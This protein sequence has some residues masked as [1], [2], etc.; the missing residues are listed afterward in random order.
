[1]TNSLAVVLPARI[2]LF[3]EPKALWY[4]NRASGLV[5]LVL[6]TIVL[7]FG[8]MA[9]RK[10][11][12]GHLPR[13][14]S[15]EV[16]RALALTAVAFLVLHIVTAVLDDFVSIDLINVV[17]PWGAGWKPRWIGLGAVAFDL[18][19]A[20]VVTSLLRD[21]MPEGRWRAIHL[22]VF[23]MWP[24]AWLHALGAGT[25]ARDP[26]YLIISIVC[27]I[28]VLVA[29]TFRWIRPAPVPVPQAG[30]WANQPNA[31][32]RRGRDS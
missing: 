11:A 5:L 9:A 21:R 4:L 6:L 2:V 30:G 13:F 27:A 18:L 22:L 29:G 20:V 25:D 14:V 16:H 17:I 19:I 31:T 1:M 32:S 3:G 10:S 8:V 24:I 26:L 23:A 7:V 28:A 15:N 12:G